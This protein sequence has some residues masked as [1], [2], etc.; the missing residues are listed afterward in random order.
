MKWGEPKR[1]HKA[2][3]WTFTWDGHGWWGENDSIGL[4][5]SGGPGCW[6]VSGTK[7][8][9]PEDYDIV[10]LEENIPRLK[11]ACEKAQEIVDAQEYN[12]PD[13]PEAYF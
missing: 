3:G 10:E 11:D 13:G 12:G 9:T 1:E 4:D 8:S 6:M 7:G 5:V 2:D